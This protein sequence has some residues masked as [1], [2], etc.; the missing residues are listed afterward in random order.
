MWMVIGLLII[1]GSL[2]TLEIGTPKEPGPGLF[3]LLI[4]S[5]VSVFSG[6]VLILATFSKESKKSNVVDLWR[7]LSWSKAA[8]TVIALF[9]YSLLLNILGFLIT[10]FLLLIFL[11]KVV[12]PQK[13]KVAV[14]ISVLA[15][16]LSY[17]IFDRIL[18]V[19]LPRGVGDFWGF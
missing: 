3:P 14:P 13:T 1:I 4:G 6:G 16:V 10:T 7:G 5:L 9:V 11:M 17:W 18:Q 19:Q 15:S 12:E 8:Y 2:V